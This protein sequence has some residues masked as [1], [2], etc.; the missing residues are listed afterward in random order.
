[1]PLKSN[2]KNWLQLICRFGSSPAHTSLQL[3][4]LCCLSSC[5][6]FFFCRGSTIIENRITS[7]HQ[8]CIGTKDLVTFIS[9]WW[10]MKETDYWETSSILS[11]PSRCSSLSTL[12]AA[13][14]N[15]LFLS[16]LTSPWHSILPSF[17]IHR[18]ILDTKQFCPLLPSKP[19][20]DPN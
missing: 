13:E 16:L 17:G 14:S 8:C 10:I 3:L 19:S 9:G 7:N 11:F 12:T 20:Q 5:T 1:M 6:C 4:S 15:E 2:V 18:V